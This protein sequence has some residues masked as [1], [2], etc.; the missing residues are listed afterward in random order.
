MCTHMRHINSLKGI[1]ILEKNNIIATK[2][3]YVWNTAAGL[4]NAAEA[5]FMS[6]IVT[7]TTGLHDAGLL[8]IAFAVGNIMMTIGKFGVRNYQVTD[9]E[10][11]YDFEDYIVLRIFSTIFMI[12]CSVSYLF[13]CFCFS[14]Y[15]QEKIWVVG[16]I[17][18]I[19]AIEAFEDV[20][21]GEYQLEGYLAEGAQLFCIRWGGILAVF[22]VVILIIKNMLWA[23][24]IGCAVSLIIF[25]IAVNRSYHKLFAGRKLNIFHRA[26]G[27]K[28]ISLI[29]TV[30]PL[31]L[32][33]FLT[34]YV[35]NAPKYAIDGQLSE[36]TQACYGFVA[37]PVFVIGL[38]NNFL[39]QPT[40]VQ[41]S[42]E[43]N[44][45][46]YAKMKKRVKKQIVLLF[47]MTVIILGGAYFLGIPVLSWLY[48]TDLTGYKREL[49]VLL[50]G[51]SFLALSG[52]FSVLLTIMRYQRDL[53]LSYVIIA[54]LAFTILNKLV[55]IWGT[56]GVAVGYAVLMIVLAIL[57]GIDFHIRIVYRSKDLE[58]SNQKC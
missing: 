46:Q 19:Y 38:L 6:M 43:W 45:R 16:T 28:V 10:H 29:H 21:W 37:M 11:K 49:M 9:V 15:S 25:L 14:N 20:V 53:L 48:A 47:A 51:G 35:N 8:T 50:L 1:Y 7:R 41:M 18:G 32:V 22:A 40:L 44:N 2:D 54:L 27:A 24:L 3:D 36:E 17:I 58:K 56:M 26:R 12:L 57:Y 23:L 42:I 33:S 5:V 31:F 4:L 34:F 52:Y 13:Y 39:Y 55:A 30:L